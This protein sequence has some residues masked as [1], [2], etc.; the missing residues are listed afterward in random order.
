LV[1]LATALAACGDD[2][3]TGSTG[4]TTSGTTGSGGAG[5]ATT[6]SAGGQG[7][8]A[9]GGGTTSTTG[10]GGSSTGGGGA[11]GSSTGG[12]GAGGAMGTGGSGTGG[13]VPD[14]D[15]DGDG[16]TLAQGDCCDAVGPACSDP[17]KVNP[18]AF[19]YLGNGVDDDCDPA[20]SDTMAVADCSP[21]P[22][23]APTSAADLVKAMDLCQ[24]T[25]ENP[26]LSQKHWGV[27]DASLTLVD[28]TGAPKDL[29]VGV[30]GN[31]GSFV[32]PKRGA[33]LAALSSGTGRKESDPG[34]VHPQNGGAGQTGNYDAMTQTSAPS[35][36]LA[37]HGGVLPNPGNCPAC[38]GSNCTT[39]YDGTRLRVRLR[40]P[41]NAR[42]FSYDLKF[43]SAEFPEFVC[44][45]Y[46]DFFLT[47]LTSSWT[48]DPNDPSQ[49]PL[50]VDRNIATDSL[51]NTLSVN[52]AFLTVCF[53]PLGA[54]AGSCPD[55]TLDLIGNGMG[56]WSGNLKDGGGTTWLTNEAP[57]VPGETIELEFMIWD[58][59]DHNVD[60]VALLDHFKWQIDPA[61]VGLHQ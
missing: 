47:L 32:M 55:G 48:P 37:A 59:G 38:V 46:N 51:G 14:P 26:P 11:G 1:A 58:S 5:G 45:A 40:V 16:W 53:P 36:Y 12:G 28:G 15:L 44:K 34:Y 41:T 25:T 4:S 23:V 54:P 27:I 20:T 33:T 2:G 39:A 9:T 42:S 21:S 61:S 22:L 60:S 3:S 19:E 57:V 49:V 43:Y 8:G 35:A 17:A 24:T 10:T 52:N 7:T 56:G 50:P 30:L 29:Q 18:G 31:Y 6:T 13:A